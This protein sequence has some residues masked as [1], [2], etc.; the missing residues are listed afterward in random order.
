MLEWLRARRAARKLSLRDRGKTVSWKEFDPDANVY[1]DIWLT[2][3]LCN[4]QIRIGINQEGFPVQYCWRCE[5]LICGQ[6]PDGSR[7]I[8]FV[9][10]MD[11][12]V[13]AELN[14]LEKE[15]RL[16]RADLLYEALD[17]FRMC[18]DQLKLGHRVVILDKSHTVVN[19]IDF[20]KWI[21]SGDDGWRREVE[22]EDESEEDKSSGE[23]NGPA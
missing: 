18:I 5:T 9:F 12:K 19:V 22:T 13:D 14:Q 6:L 15:C 20:G 4:T 10:S 21:Y 3:D 11:E 1:V 8:F 16:E 23:D 7:R 17:V 2:C